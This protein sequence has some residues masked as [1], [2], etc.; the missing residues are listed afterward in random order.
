MECDVSGGRG[1]IPVI[2]AAAV[3]LAGLAA[4]VAG[5]L[6]QRL[7]LLLQQLIQGF[8]YTSSN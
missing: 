8:F 2:V 6:R 4:L 5:G 7:R 1:K 3:A